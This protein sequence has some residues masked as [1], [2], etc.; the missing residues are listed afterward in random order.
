MII[1]LISGPLD[2]EQLSYPGAPAHFLIAS[3]HPDKPI[4]RCTCCECCAQKEEFLR[5]EFIGYERRYVD[6]M[7]EPIT[8]FKLPGQE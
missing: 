8:H 6:V 2:G 3:E 5:Y 4:Y 7:A 1:E